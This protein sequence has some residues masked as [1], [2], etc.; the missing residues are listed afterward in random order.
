MRGC[1]IR[2]GCLYKPDAE[3]ERIWVKEAEARWA[4]FERGEVETVPYESVMARYR[5]C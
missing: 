1:L 4:A 3:I 5:D 2:T